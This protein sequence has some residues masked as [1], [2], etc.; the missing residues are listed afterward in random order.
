[1]KKIIYFHWS[2][3]IGYSL[4]V[5]R[6]TKTVTTSLP[7]TNALTLT[8]LVSGLCRL[9]AKKEKKT[10]KISL[11]LIQQTIIYLLPQSYRIL[12]YHY[13]INTAQTTI[14]M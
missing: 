12:K 10:N 14:L 9:K 4:T 7:K 3:L 1:M 8:F 13:Y 5:K 2:V 6:L 11:L